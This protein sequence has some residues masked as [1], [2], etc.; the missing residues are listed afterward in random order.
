MRNLKGEVHVNV[1]NPLEYPAYYTEHV[2]VYVIV[3]IVGHASG[4][5]TDDAVI[6]WLLPGC[7]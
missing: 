6:D 2:R 3:Y 1:S 4:R 7:Q 5:V